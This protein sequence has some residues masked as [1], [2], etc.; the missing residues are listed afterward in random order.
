MDWIPVILY[1]HQSTCYFRLRQHRNGS[2]LDYASNWCV[3]E[4]GNTASGINRLTA[5]PPW[6]FNRPMHDAATMGRHVILEW[7]IGFPYRPPLLLVCQGGIDFHWHDG[8]KNRR[9]YKGTQFPLSLITH[10]LSFSNLLVIFKP[11]TSNISCLHL[12]TV[13]PS[14][15]WSWLQQR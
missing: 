8:R 1:I 3:P 6:L 12:Q 5:K 10:L 9:T 14:P 15:R 2:Y 4:T 7:R 11:P 13:Y